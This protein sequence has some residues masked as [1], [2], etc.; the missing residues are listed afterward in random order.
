MKPLTCLFSI[1]FLLGTFP[2]LCQE[3][4]PELTTDRPDQTES[5]SVVPRRALQV[6]TG[7]VLQK[8]RGEVV[9]LKNIAYNATLLRYGLTKNFEVR[10]GFDY[11]GE[12]A[13]FSNSGF[14]YNLSGLGPLYTGFK[15]RMLEEQGW[16]PEMAFLGGVVWPFPASDDFRPGYASARMRFAFSHTLAPSLSLGYNLGAEW[17]GNT[18][19]PTWPYSIALGIAVAPRLG[20]FMESYGVWQD[21]PE[22]KADAGITFLALPNLQL[23][24]SLGVG[25]TEDA[26]D[27][28]MG[29]G[30]SFRL[31]E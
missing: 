5:S 23:D 30:V 2:V 27:H 10:L 18:P 19:M 20:V 16:I 26:A 12:K 29:F 15:T 9:T 25:L 21:V 7:F 1:L 4:V 8:D 13:E 11:L 6:E 14:S 17:D 3:E 28:F 31:P 22:H 24:L